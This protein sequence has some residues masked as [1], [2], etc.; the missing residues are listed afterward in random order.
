MP[1]EPLTERERFPLLTAAGRDMLRRLRQHPHGP[2]FN[3]PCGERLDAAGLANV[4]D[5]AAALATRRTGW[6]FGETP[7]WLKEFVRYCRDEVPFYRARADWPDDFFSLPS[8]TRTDI[9]REP[10]SFVP[11]AADLSQLVVYRTSGTTGNLLNLIAHPV[12]PNRYLPL[13]E[14]AL[15]AYGVAIEG[16]HRVSIIQ[17]C[18]QRRTFTLASVMSY[19]DSAGFAKINLNPPDWTSPDDRVRFLDDCDAEIYTGDPFAFA[20][21]ARLELKTRPKALVSSAT[22]LLPDQRA[23]LEAHFGCPLI[24]MYA[25]NEAGPVAF[26]REAGHE[27]LPHDLYVEILD[28]AGRPMPAGE[29][30][31]IVVTGGVNP[32]LPLI[33][34]RTGDFAALDFAGPLPRLVD[35]AGRK[36]VHFCTASGKVVSSIDVTVALFDIPLSFYA[37]HQSVD[38]AMTLRTRCDAAT[39]TRVE[40]AFRDLFGPEQSVTIEQLPLDHVWEGKWIQYHS[41]ACPP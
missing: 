8:T 7:G 16:G 40:D 29:R 14:T 2:R 19:F 17:V 9:R 32:N 11:D 18:S 35:F 21:L 41:A 30:G 13:I 25:L 39:Q 5:Y 37:L 33:R 20:E 34:Y 1:E 4:R 22:T 23:F 27:V 12:A 38:Y 28:D 3:Y 31:E 36:P 10:W 24:D 26:S 15:A 6:R